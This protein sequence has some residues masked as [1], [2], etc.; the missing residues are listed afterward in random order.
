MLMRVKLP[1][2]ATTTSQ[3]EPLR[4]DGVGGDGAAAGGN[5]ARFLFILA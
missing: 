3:Q 4:G 1:G 5:R 2:V